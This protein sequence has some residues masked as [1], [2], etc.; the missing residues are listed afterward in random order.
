M[1]RGS[2]FGMPRAVSGDLDRRRLLGELLGDWRR[3]PVVLDVD[4][5]ISTFGCLPGGYR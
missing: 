4:I 5:K 3:V 1:F 2:G